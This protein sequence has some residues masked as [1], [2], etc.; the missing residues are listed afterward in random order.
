M[1]YSPESGF[2]RSPGSPVGVK[3]IR[4]KIIELQ[5]MISQCDN[6]EQALNGWRELCAYG[7]ALIL[8]TRQQ[9]MLPKKNEGGTDWDA[10]VVKLRDDWDKLKTSEKTEISLVREGNRE[11]YSIQW[12]S[13]VGTFAPAEFE[14]GIRIMDKEKYN[15]ICHR[16]MQFWGLC[17]AV[18][19]AS[20]VFLIDSKIEIPEKPLNVYTEK[21]MGDDITGRRMPRRQNA[22][23]QPR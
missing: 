21:D 9:K 3:N 1:G 23:R 17:E 18:L 19:F 10:M 22:Q 15:A 7:L 2:G 8:D 6:D 4:S 20:G 13:Y 14:L 11:K 16:L 12:D 5:D